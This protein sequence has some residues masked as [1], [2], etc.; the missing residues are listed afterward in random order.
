MIYYRGGSKELRITILGAGSILP[1]KERF[2]SGILLESGEL[3]KVL[4]DIGPG[5]LEK[6]RE[7]G[8]DP[9]E[10]KRV[11][12]THLH[13]DHVLDLLALI[14]IKAYLPERR[15]TIYGPR[16]I[17][18]WLDLLTTDN[19]L[20]GYLSRMGCKDYLDVHECW[21]TSTTIENGIKLST[22]PVEHFNGIA[23]RL[24]FL[25]GIS[26]TYSGDTVPDDRLID[27]ARGSRILIHECSLPS[28][29]MRGKHTSDEDLV[30]I[31]REL[32]PEI[33]IV[34]HLYPEMEKQVDVLRE[35]LRS[36]FAGKI[37]IP[38]DLTTIEV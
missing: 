19:M 3:G 20:F 18:E 5:T 31:V 12:V 34:V 2:S 17:S 38:R 15:L 30:E 36:A 21:E 13:V 32:Q 37:Y 6:L 16:G 14:K 9:G 35:K 23:Y 27:L 26:L 33:L 10:I 22:T 4:L 25:G 1:T 29:K 28:D 7:M 8:V 11:F 24:D